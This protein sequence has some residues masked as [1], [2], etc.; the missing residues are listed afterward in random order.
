LASLAVQIDDAVHP[1]GLAHIFEQLDRGNDG[2]DHT[3]LPYARPAMSPQYSR[4]LSTE[5][6]TYERDEA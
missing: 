5:P 4:A 2:Q 3:V 6:E 1:V